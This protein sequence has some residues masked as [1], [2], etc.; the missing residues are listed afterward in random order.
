MRKGFTL[1]ELLAVVGILSFILMGVTQLLGS[2]LAGSGK[3]NSLQ[4]VKQNGQFAISTMERTVRRAKTLTACSDGTLIVIVP[5]TTG[6][7]TYAFAL[8]GNRL[9]RNDINLTDTDIQVT[10]FSCSPTPATAGN[11]AV[12]DISLTIEKSGLPVE[13]SVVSTTFNTSVSLRTY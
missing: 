8:S 7:V 10:D 3:S 11:P 2:T 9:Q 1:L 4:I 12:V 6:D 13:N 5:E